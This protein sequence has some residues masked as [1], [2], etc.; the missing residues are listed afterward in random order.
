VSEDELRDQAAMMQEFED[1]QL[2]LALAASLEEGENRHGGGREG[3]GEIGS[4]AARDHALEHTDLAD[5]GEGGFLCDDVEN[6]PKPTPQP[7]L[8]LSPSDAALEPYGGPA[9]PVPHAAAAVA[10][11]V[12][13]TPPH[14]KDREAAA[15]LSPPWMHQDA[16]QP[17]GRIA[18]YRSNAHEDGQQSAGVGPLVADLECGGP[19]AIPGAAP[20]SVASRARAAGL[21]VGSLTS[22]FFDD[23]TREWRCE[24]CGGDHARA[25]QRLLAPLPPNLLLHLK[26][27]HS[28]P[29]TG[30]T[31]KLTTRLA[32]DERLCLSPHLEQS[33]EGVDTDAV[34]AGGGGGE[35]TEPGQ[36]RL[37]ALVS[38]HGEQCWSGHYTCSAR[39]GEGEQWACYDDSHVSV[40][41]DDPT[42]TPT[43]MRG[44]YL[45]LYERVEQHAE[46]QVEPPEMVD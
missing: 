22:R 36:Y 35:G 21:T 16:E 37:R 24:R 43:A 17:E 14:R 7:T 23:E 20:S 34:A 26:R 28:D 41:S 13:R 39:V 8:L 29:R 10:G 15:S 5:H 42:C 2:A 12:P 1:H 45:L 38:H 30:L 6:S 40:L 31:T 44:A 27:F 3:G 9:S 33:L 46:Q 4:A 11:D 19:R 25:S 18:T 32:L